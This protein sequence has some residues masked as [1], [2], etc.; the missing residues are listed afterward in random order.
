MNI[1]LFYWKNEFFKHEF[2]NQICED[3]PYE[4]QNLVLVGFPGIMKEL[5]ALDAPEA[6]QITEIV[7]HILV[8]A[9]LHFTNQNCP[10]LEQESYQN[11]ICRFWVMGQ[12]G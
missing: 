8:N 11:I 7:G 4:A 5:P 6:R 3:A 10:Y 12:G 9:L 2:Q 1:Q